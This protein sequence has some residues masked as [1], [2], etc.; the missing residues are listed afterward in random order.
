MEK[1]ALDRDKIGRNAR[2]KVR[3]SMASADQTEGTKSLT[4]IS[5]TS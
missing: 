2:Y 1:V 4:D 5:T 3:G